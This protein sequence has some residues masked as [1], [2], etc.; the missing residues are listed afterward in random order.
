MWKNFEGFRFSRPHNVQT[1]D[2]GCFQ[3]GH[4]G[5]GII[6]TEHSAQINRL[7]CSL[8]FKNLQNIKII[9][10]Y[11]NFN[12]YDKVFLKIRAGEVAQLMK[13][14]QYLSSI[15][16]THVKKVGMVVHT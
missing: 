15:T 12:R 16:R 9:K 5:Y 2:W 13:C 3:I 6:N 1:A 4:C 14:V 10:F 11:S 7:N 8:F